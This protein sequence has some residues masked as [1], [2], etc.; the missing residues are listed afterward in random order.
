M[1]G[2]ESLLRSHQSLSYSRISQ[3]F[4]EPEGLLPCSKEPI[5]GLY[6]EPDE[7]NPEQPILFL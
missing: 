7:S 6:P 4:I 2:A 3:D 5:T 1:H